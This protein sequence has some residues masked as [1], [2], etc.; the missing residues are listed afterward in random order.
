MEHLFLS[1]KSIFKMLKDLQDQI[2]ESFKT[3]RE[4][5]GNIWESDF[6]DPFDIM[7]I[8]NAIKATPIEDR[9]ELELRTH[10]L[11]HQITFYEK[12]D[13]DEPELTKK[14]K[15]KWLIALISTYWKVET[16]MYDT[17]VIYM[18]KLFRLLQDVKT[19]MGDDEDEKDKDKGKN[20]DEDKKKKD[21]KGLGD[22]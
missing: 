17:I 7:I 12:E 8:F 10:E 6:K 4:A 14:V 1:V 16:K 19:L 13:D 21:F 2:K 11:I 18:N 3:V 15:V 5:M 20:K 9:K 22:H